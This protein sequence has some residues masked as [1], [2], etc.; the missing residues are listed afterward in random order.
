MGEDAIE[1]I[2]AGT[3]V[4][5][6]F[7]A[8][9]AAESPAPVSASQP[10]SPSA[11]RGATSS[12][13]FGKDKVSLSEEPEESEGASQEQGS[14]IAQNMKQSMQPPSDEKGSGKL[15][16]QAV[17]KTDAP[18]LARG[19]GM[20]GKPDAS[21]SDLQKQLRG[22]GLDVGRS[23]AKRDGI[24]GRFGQQTER[25][26][27]QA[28]E[29]LG[30]PVT[31]QADAKTLEGLKTLQSGRNQAD[32]SNRGANAPPGS[33]AGPGAGSGPGATAGGTA[34]PSADGRPGTVG[35]AADAMKPGASDLKAGPNGR[36]NPADLQKYIEDKI[37]GSKLNGYVPKDGGRYGIDGSPKSWARY[38][39]QLANKESGFNTN[40]VSEPH[41]FRGGSRGLF[42]LSFDDARNYG[43]NGGRP[44]SPQQ[45]A[46]PKTNTDAAIAIQERLITRAGSIRGGAGRYWGPIQRG[47]TPRAG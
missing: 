3:D 29:K 26:V 16:A 18:A 17:N 28:Q 45:L 35:E 31:G 36:V 4:S 40:D 39:T 25:A 15:E 46:D 8:G 14:E 7:S 20:K 9:T 34:Q 37:T 12:D 22:A 27:R 11:E 6:G 21:V 24:D 1:P 13:A 44:F 47:W 30:L 41:A 10:A 32:T 33:T 38:L 19:S 42:Q 23:G 5:G 2:G 43:L